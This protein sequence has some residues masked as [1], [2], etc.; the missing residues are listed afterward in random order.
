MQLEY[1]VSD[2]ENRWGVLVMLSSTDVQAIYASDT[3]P[4]IIQICK[5][6]VETA[7]RAALA[8]KLGDHYDASLMSD[9]ESLT[10]EPAFL[11]TI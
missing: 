6:T 10:Y 11:W 9:V 8:K 3:T 2:P 4:Q 5:D 1:L 7:V